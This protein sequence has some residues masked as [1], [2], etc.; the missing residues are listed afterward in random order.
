LNN[1]EV[2]EVLFDISRLLELEGDGAY[3]IRAYRKAAQSIEGLEGDVN[4]YYREGRLQEI[5]GIGESIART[6]AELLDTGR[7]GLYEALKKEVPPELYEVIEVPGIGRKTA[8]KV[9][10]ALGAK[11]IE[12]F[13]R[14]AKSHQIRKVRGLGEKVEKRVLESIERYHELQGEV[15]I[16]I[17]RARAIALEL[18]SYFADC[19]GL[20]RADVVGSIRRWKTMVGDVNILAIAED[21]EKA[22]DCFCSTPVSTVVREQS[23]HHAR[24]TTRYRMDATLYVARSE[25]YGFHMLWGTGSHEHLE[26]LSFYAAGCGIRLDHNGYFVEA[27]GERKTFPA[28]EDIYASLGLQYIPPEIRQGIQEVTAACE[29]T[30]PE[31]VTQEDM[32]G[33]LHVHTDWSDGA[34]SINDMA[35]AAQARGY[36]YIAICDHS[37][38]LHIANGLSIEKLRDQ[39]VKIDELNDTLEKFSILKGSEVDI[40]SDGSLDLPDDVLEDLDVVVGSVHT[41][42]RQEPDVI[43]R[44]VITALENEHLTILAHPTSRVL[45]GRPPMALDMDRI[46]ETAKEHGKVLEVNAYPS[47]LDLSDVNVRKAMDAGVMISIDTDAHSI[48]ELCFMDYGVH[49]AQRGWATPARTLNTLSYEALAAFLHLG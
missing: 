17:Y 44:R 16:P 27:T 3:R 31:L 32:K 7:S 26:R 30:I 19:E 15:R 10:R 18:M 28:E 33:D 38:S 21:P 48:P 14:A 23:D 11:T 49:N 45:G 36:E 1:R 13:R 39:M 5:P 25:D 12:E 6:V 29:G 40:L 22:L 47:R 41:N 35:M 42:M 24:V 2:A 20:V 34:D 46:I 43:T 37:R 9:N 4:E 8:L